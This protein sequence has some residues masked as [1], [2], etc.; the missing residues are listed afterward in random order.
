MKDFEE[1]CKVYGKKIPEFP[2][3]NFRNMMGSVLPY[4]HTKEIPWNLVLPEHAYSHACKTRDLEQQQI[5][6]EI[7]TDIKYYTSVYSETKTVFDYLQP[8]KVNGLKF[9][10]LSMDKENQVFLDGFQPDAQ[11]F[12]DVPKYSICDTVTGRQKITSGPN[13]LLLPKKLRGVLQ[14]RFGKDGAIYYLDFTSLEPRVLLSI[15]SMFEASGSL[16][17]GDVPLSLYSEY[18]AD[19]YSDALKKMKLSSEINRDTLKQ[20]IL[21]QLYGQAKSAT[22]DLLEKQNVRDPDEVVEMVNEYFGID[23]MKE[24]IRVAHQSTGETFLR[25]FYRKHVIPSDSKPHVLLNYFIQSTAVDVAL[26]G[27]KKILER[28]ATTTQV[29]NLIVPI[30]VLHDALFLDIHNDVAHLIPKLC[31]LGSKNIPGFGTQNFYLT[32]TK[33]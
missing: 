22:I 13:I 26:F 1:I 2:G 9:K 23:F 20:I 18:P 4:G 27:F 16:L 17:I 15:K 10:L 19:I 30:Y 11:G 28:L 5:L 8:A 24:Q 3:E 31:T 32:G 12:L 29:Q 7:G 6:S 33:L 25:T 14:S 21:P